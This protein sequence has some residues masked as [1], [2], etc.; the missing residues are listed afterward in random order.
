MTPA[1]PRSHY[2]NDP[3]YRFIVSYEG[4]DVYSR[5]RFATGYMIVKDDSAWGGASYTLS[6]IQLYSHVETKH[7]RYAVILA[8][9]KLQGL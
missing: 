3:A 4:W 7:N 9:I 5:S 8:A 6:T 2:A 1:H